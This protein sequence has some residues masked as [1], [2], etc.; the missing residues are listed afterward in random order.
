MCLVRGERAPIARLHPAIKGVWGAQ[1]AGARIV[2][3][4]C[5]AFTSYGQEQG[6]NAPV[7]EAAAFAYTTSSRVADRV[8]GVN[9]A[10]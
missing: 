10:V 2:S 9:P 8:I 5:D 4:N 1:T 3:F 6:A 7:S